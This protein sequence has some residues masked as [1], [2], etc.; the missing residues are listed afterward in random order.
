MCQSPRTSRAPPATFAPPPDN[1]AKDEA[2]P[3]V[4]KAW[5]YISSL[6]KHH[7]GVRDLSGLGLLRIRGAHPNRTIRIDVVGQPLDTCDNV[8][9]RRTS[10]GRRQPQSIN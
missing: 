6:P 1:P 5:L 10:R 7:Q 8:F 3:T 4:H 9:T 2:V